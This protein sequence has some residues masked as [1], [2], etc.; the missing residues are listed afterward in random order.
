[1]RAPDFWERD[2]GLL[3]RLLWPA[4]AVYAAAGALRRRIGP[5][6]SVE[7]PVVCVGNLV[8]GG[9]GKTPVAISLALHL[10]DADLRPHFLSRGY[11]GRERGPLR[12]DRD[13]HDHRAVGDEPLLL[14]E[15]APTW[16]GRDRLATARAA[17]GAGA[18]LLL[19]DD[20]FQNPRLAKDLSLVVVDAA[21]GFGNG[22]VIPAGPLREP[23]QTGLARADAVVLLGEGS[24]PPLPPDLPVLRARL[25]PAPSTERLVGHDILAFAGI[26]RPA[27]F[28]NMLRDVGCR[29]VETLAFP[30]HHRYGPDEVMA[31]CE[32]AQRVGAVPVTTA[33][34][35][36]RLPPEARPMVET[37][38]VLVEWRDVAALNALLAPVLRAVQEP[39]AR[40]GFPV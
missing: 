1:M 34:D 25:A 33:K 10:M 37:V 22:R 20:G 40:T 16:V 27:K 3:P 5:R 13:R 24:A 30:D 8:A 36:V 26:G 32:R 17:V 38:E 39:A 23:V 35:R 19:L 21:Y 29:L 31:L 9:A 28:F 11:G 7:V 12:V 6:G 2:H 14:A 18:D 15:I 4:A